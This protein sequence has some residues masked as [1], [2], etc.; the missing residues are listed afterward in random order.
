[1]KEAGVVSKQA[2]KHYYKTAKQE[3]TAPGAGSTSPAIET[4]VR[5]GTRNRVAARQS[6]LRTR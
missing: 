3:A 1:M 2:R 6:S 5:Q 4:A